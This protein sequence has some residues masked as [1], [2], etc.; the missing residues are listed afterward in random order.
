[1][2]VLVAIAAV[3]VFAGEAPAR[4]PRWSRFELTLKNPT[5]YADPYRDVTLD[6][7]YTRPDGTKIAFWGFHDG[8]DIWRARFMPDAL[9]RWRYEAKF[10]DS[11]AAATRGTFDCVAS[12]LPG[13][14][15]VHAAN[16]IWFGWRGGEAALLRALHVGDRFFAKN[17]D[18]PATADDGDKRTAFLDWAQPQGYNT[19]SIASHYLNRDAKGRGEGWDTPKLWPLDAAEFRRMERMLDELAARRFNVY[20]FAGFFGRASHFPRDASDQTLYLRYTLAR[21]A[22]FWNLLFNVSGPEPLLRREPVLTIDEINRLGAEIAR[23]DPFQH[24]LSVHNAPDADPFKDEAWLS[25]GTLQGPKTFDR[26]KLRDGLLRLHHPK[27]PLLAQETLWSGNSIHIRA[28]KGADYSDTDLRKNAFAIHFSGANLVFADN[29]GDSSTGFT[30]TMDPAERRQPR[31]DILKRV[32][33]TFAALPWQRTTPRP[34]LVTH[35][36]GG[37]AFCLADPGRT[38]LVYLDSGGSVDVQISGG[39]YRVEW[40]NAQSAADRRPAAPSD[41]GKNLAAPREGDDWILQLTR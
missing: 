39:P 31:H 29:N 6:V 7:S 5:R 38:Y 23:L 20:P 25:Y 14:I 13:Q 30:G 27:K 1:V 16:P 4:V 40:I 3:H 12:D 33:D 35:A 36:T 19:L 37:N 26:A 17:W 24:P 21:L 11:S 18:D 32:W 9:G 15:S 41:D 2:L 28:N 22:P 10:S 34:E 8:D